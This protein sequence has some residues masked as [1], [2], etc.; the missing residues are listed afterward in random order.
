MLDDARYL[1][2]V[3]FRSRCYSDTYRGIEGLVGLGGDR[4]CDPRNDR[5]VTSILLLQTNLE[6]R[7]HLSTMLRANE[8][9]FGW[10]E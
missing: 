2:H 7:F 4:T 1:G 6:A 5:A 10:N 9:Y 8:P 3:T